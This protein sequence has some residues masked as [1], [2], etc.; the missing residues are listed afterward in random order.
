VTPRFSL[1]CT[2][3]MLEACRALCAEAPGHVF[4]TSHINEN[5]AEIQA[6]AELF[7]WSHDYL[8][9]YERFGLVRCRAVFPATST[10]R[11]TS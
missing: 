7:P 5:P 2:D 3:A 11:A 9:T 1:S 6:V 8:E 4:F 10:R